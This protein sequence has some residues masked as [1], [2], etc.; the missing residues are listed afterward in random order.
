MSKL[1]RPIIISFYAKKPGYRFNR[2]WKIFRENVRKPKSIDRG[3]RQA[4]K[5]KF[6]HMAGGFLNIKE[7][8]KPVIFLPKVIKMSKHRTTIRKGLVSRMITQ[9]EL[10]HWKQAKS[11]SMKPPENIYQTVKSEIPAYIYGFRKTAKYVKNI[12]KRGWKE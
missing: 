10:Y 8:K 7:L 5:E 9:H 6:K 11:F 2:L 3:T 12:F 4:F 1:S